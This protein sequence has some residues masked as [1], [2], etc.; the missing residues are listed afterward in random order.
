MDK[1]Y[2]AKTNP[3]AIIPSKIEEN[4]GMDIYPCFEEDFIWIKPHNTAMIPT[5][6]ASACSSNYYFQ[7]F[8]RGSTGTK[9]IGQRCGVI[10]SGYRNEWF[11]PITNHNYKQLII[12]K[13]NIS[14][15]EVLE[16]LFG[17]TRGSNDNFIF[18]PYE[19]AICQA[20]LLPVPKIEVNEI[21]YNDIL[22]ITSERGLGNLGSSGK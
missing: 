1:I 16:E 10:D 21:S 9:G 2:F 5:G 11:V 12:I 15:S 6:I 8:E 22:E 14:K 3:N 18:Y 20:V 19:K 17:T 13:E 7:L 4:A